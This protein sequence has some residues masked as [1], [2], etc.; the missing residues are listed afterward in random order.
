MGSSQVCTCVP[1]VVGCSQPFPSPF[2]PLAP[3]HLL[4]SLDQRIMVLDFVLVTL[5]AGFSLGQG[6]FLQTLFSTNFAPPRT[7]KSNLYPFY[8]LFLIK[9]PYYIK[10]HFNFLFSKS[11]GMGDMRRGRGSSPPSRAT[12][13][14]AHLFRPLYPKVLHMTI[15]LYS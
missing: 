4:A 8:S 7:L 3:C 13:M 12:T 11:L 6:P 1:I 15:F 14:V 10:Y 9:Y 2:V 5:G